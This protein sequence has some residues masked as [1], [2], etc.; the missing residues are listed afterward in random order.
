MPAVALRRPGW[1]PRSGDRWHRVA[2]LDAAARAL[3]SVGGRAL[4]TVGRQGVAAF[5]TVSDVW[6]LLRC[7][8]APSD[9]L[10]P[11]SQ[12]LLT[13]GPFTVAGELALL[14]DHAIDV[15]VTKDSGG[16]ATAA[17]LDA[18]RELGLPVV[19]VDR[20]PGPGLPS[21]ADV[22]AVIAWLTDLR[23]A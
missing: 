8:D 11:R 22:D 16:S 14:R 1:S 2:D 3:P 21:V 13:R 7:I 17:K 10:P 15:V 12:V 18:A 4:L 20:P 19:V 6:F 23:S 9:P 5:A